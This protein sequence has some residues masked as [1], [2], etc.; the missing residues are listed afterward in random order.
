MLNRQQTNITIHC[1]KLSD[2]SIVL[3]NWSVH[4]Q[5]VFD[6]IEVKVDLT[7]KRRGMNDHDT[8]GQQ[9]INFVHAKN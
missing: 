1:N 5:G 9:I 2:I 3:T 7:I 4:K 6:I 8:I